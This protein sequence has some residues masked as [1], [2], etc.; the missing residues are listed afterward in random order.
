MSEWGIRWLAV[1]RNIII[2]QN[3]NV[4]SIPSGRKV[5]N[6]VPPINKTNIRT[7]VRKPHI[8][9]N[10]KI[11]LKILRRLNCL[12]EEANEAKNSYDWNELR[13]LFFEVNIISFC[14]KRKVESQVDHHTQ[15][16]TKCKHRELEKEHYTM[17]TLPELPEKVSLVNAKSCNHNPA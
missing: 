16:N 14:H 17:R 15:V 5:I 10:E 7:G 4:P 3:I 12:P 2:P 11:R 1:A 8:G 9:H 13:M 6:I